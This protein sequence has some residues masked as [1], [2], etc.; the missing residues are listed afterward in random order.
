[1]PSGCCASWCPGTEGD[2]KGVDWIDCAVW[3][4]RLRRSVAGWGTGDVGR[5]RRARCVGG[6]TGWPGRRRRGSRWRPAAAGSSVAQIPHEHAHV[7]LRLEGGGL[8]GEQLTRA[9]RAGHLV[10]V[11]AGSSTASALRRRAPAPRRRCGGRPA[12]PRGPSRPAAA[13]RAAAVTSSGEAPVGPQRRPVLTVVQDDGV[14]ERG[15]R[16]VAAGVPAEVVAA[17][18]GDLLDGASASAGGWCGGSRPARAGCR[19]GRPA[20]P[21][22]GPRR[23]R[24]AAPGAGR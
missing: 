4:G 5:G 2:R 13:S 21:G 1:M 11:G 7:R 24:R 6:S 20:S 10:E 16:L 8:L 14:L 22:S 18:G 3:G 15:Q 9:G 19:P 12:A 17:L 23:C